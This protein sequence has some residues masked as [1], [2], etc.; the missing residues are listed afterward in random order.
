MASDSKDTKF[1]SAYDKGGNSKFQSPYSQYAKP[2]LGNALTGERAR[3]T[4]A[5]PFIGVTM[6]GMTV[7]YTGNNESMAK[8]EANQ[9]AVA[10]HRARNRGLSG[11]T[12][13][14]LDTKTGNIKISA[15]SAVINSEAGQRIFNSD[16]MKGLSQAYKL[17]KDYKISYQELDENGNQVSTEVTIPEYVEK[18][19]S[20]LESLAN[21]ARSADKIRMSYV[22]E[23]GENA[24]KLT[25]EQIQM[26]VD[27]GGKALYLPEFAAKSQ[28]L[29]G[30]DAFTTNG[31][32]SKDDFKKFYTRDKLG[33]EEMAAL[34][35][36]IN[37]RLK[38]G[39][40]NEDEYYTDADGNKILDRNSVNEMAKALSLRNYILSNDPDSTWLQSVGDNIESLSL[41][42][43][44]GFSKVFGNIAN[45]GEAVFTLG[46]SQ[47]V[48]NYLK[49]W[50]AAIE[51]YNRD[52]LLV[53]DATAVTSVL[54]Q[55]GGTIAGTIAS[56]WLG[57][58]AISGAGKVAGAAAEKVGERVAESALGKNAVESALG[59]LAR[60]NGAYDALEL[61]KNSKDISL[62]ARMVLNFADPLEKARIAASTAKAFLDTHR[63]ANF[64]VDFLLDTVHDA[65]LYDSTTLR[66][67]LQN[68]DQETRDYW[69]GQ[70]AE[71]AKWWGGMAAGKTL[72]KW[73]GKTA[74]GQAANALMTK[75][76]NRL[77]AAVG[78]TKA[79]IKD[80]L[81]GGSVLDELN[82]KYQK[83][84]DNKQFKK[85]NR[86]SK[87]IEQET[88]NARL[89]TAR[90]NLGKLDLE[91]DG[92]KLTEKSAEKYREAVTNIKMLENAVDIYGRNIEYKRQ[93]MIGRVVD[94]STGKANFI[95]PELGGANE[96]ASK[97]Y[98][99]IAD[100]LSKN[101]LSAV[102]DSLISQDAIDYMMGQYELG[103]ARSFSEAGGE[104]AEKAAK[105]IP[106]LEEN[107]AG[108]KATLPDE[109]IRAIDSGLESKTYQSFYA[110]LNEY[111][112]SESKGLLNRDKIRSYE[113]NQIWAENGY[114]PIR[115]EHEF[116]GHWEP[117]S[118]KLE[119]IIDDDMKKLTFNVKPGQHYV[120]PELVRQSR[121]SHMAHEEVSK[122]VF[123]SYL[124]YGNDAMDVTFISGEQTE[125]V[126]KV[127][128]NKKTLE[129]TISNTASSFVDESAPIELQKTRRRKPTKNATVGKVYREEAI[130]DLSISDTSQ[131]LLD[132][133][134][135]NAKNQKLTDGVTAEN[136]DEWFGHQSK[137]VKSYLDQ[138]YSRFGRA[139][140]RDYDALQSAIAA[141]GQDFEAGLQR[142][143]LMGDP[144]FARS[145]TMNRAMRNIQDGKTAF[146][147]GVIKT[148]AKANL[149]NVLNVKVDPLVDD[150]DNIITTNLDNYVTR[151]MDNP[152]AKEAISTLAESSNGSDAVGRYIALSQLSKPRNTE[153]AYASMDKMLD[154]VI[155]KQ[156]IIV[157]DANL[158]KKQAHEMFDSIL[159]NELDGAANVARTFN[160]DLIDAD[161]IY[162]K[163][164]SLNDEIMGAEKAISADDGSGVV[165]YLDS[166]GRQ[167]FAR[168]DPAFASLYNYRF[169]MTKTEA[170]AFAKANAAMSRLFRFGTTTVNLT[171]F[172]NQMFRDFGNAI[173]VGGAWQT[174]KTNADNLTDVFGQS[175]V[176]QIKAF[177]PSGYDM[178]QVKALAEQT[179]QTVEQA[180]VSRELMRGAAIS[181]TTT[182]RTLYKEFM[183]QA[184]GRNS[185]EMLGDMKNKLQQIVDK[186]NP[187]DLLNG[188]RENYLRN[189]VYA[190]SLNDAM[191]QGYTLEQARTF[192]EFAMN[193]ATTNFSRQLYH[194]Q[195]IADSTPYFRAAINGTKSFWRMWS[196]DPVGI[197]G[198]IVGGLIL[199]T[200]YLTGASLANEEDA[201]I[202]NNIPEYQK[203]NSLVFVHDG[204]IVTIPIPQELSEVVAPFRQ[205]VEYLHGK[206]TSGFWELMSNDILG[207]SPVDLT[208][209]TTVDMDAIIRD[210]TILD[211]VSRGTSRVFSQMAPVPIKTA[212]ML[213]THTDPYTGK[214]LTDPSYGYYNE[215]TGTPEVMDYTQNAFAKWFGNL[216]GDAM[217]PALAEKIV[218]GVIGNTGL[219]VLGDLSALLQEGPEGWIDSVGSNVSTRIAKP[220]YQES[221]SIADSA[222]R[223]A[224]NQ[225]EAKKESITASRDYK[226]LC[227]KLSQEKDP[228][229][230]KGIA[231]QLQNIVNDY[232]QEVATAIK[233]LGTEYK[234]TFDR[235]KFAAVLNLLN[236]NTDPVFQNAIQNTSI[237]ASE[238]YFSG[239]DIA[240]QT[241]Q[242]L[243]VTGTNDTSIFGY[244]TI[245]KNTGK[246]VVKYSNPVAIMEME[247]AWQDQGD[248]HLNNIKAIVNR[249]NL[250]DAK[251]AV[252]K[253]VD[254]IY[255]KEKLSDSDY[256]K[257]NSIYINWNAQV[258][259]ALAPYVQQM[260][261]EAAI[262]SSSVLDYLDGLIEVPSEF[263]KDR[264]GRYVTN[265]KLGEGSAKQA[266]VRNYIKKI[267]GVNDTG[268]GGGKDYSGRK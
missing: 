187:D 5:N 80:S 153:A 251:D 88:W 188:K 31:S 124:G 186:Y 4:M 67:A 15:P 51:G 139:G 102:Q 224:V 90:R 164:K 106:V 219:D 108:Y 244:L 173:L 50:D 151:I 245:D 98:M 234:G 93:E 84:Y 216:F 249:A 74:L 54:G 254:A 204:G 215:E 243:G 163:A 122:Q 223:R 3:N 40:W 175:I 197:S 231:A 161:D 1:K 157:D 193:N 19:N 205:F 252:D 172:G 109:T 14:S 68:S 66:E 201:K 268:Y 81:A 110:Q 240:I 230:R 143:F 144:E 162:S 97:M 190:S 137:E 114:M 37:A 211:R 262:N 134:T 199:P 91:W 58:K 123:G 212:Y 26:S 221:Y 233:R 264:Y 160:P 171:S 46:Q 20:A 255:A 73:A 227:D 195:A 25:D 242:R 65:L 86:I 183:E 6:D 267:F 178:R 35:G 85:A 185:D 131:L 176:D 44:S 2:D 207:F 69:L 253:Q 52:E 133:G 140:E 95:N 126:R 181:P 177:E 266:Y 147:D 206:D 16:T 94:P 182:E 150:I 99:D 226:T 260:T 235:K 107:I 220:F 129:N 184:Y 12:S 36:M 47:A 100:S 145:S 42:A 38:Y 48:Q 236:F 87:Q 248:I 55:I 22:Q 57:G 118:G 43:L 152:G 154:D 213:A 259:S 39:G 257:I 158:I 191:K 89:R 179:G 174:I 103:L 63:T 23:F 10:E 119:N 29:K 33:R 77:A 210:P 112:T 121:I 202:Y 72:V 189:R 21:S 146:Y 132:K 45:V 127:N 28:L 203:A 18:L 155:K 128:D 263:K 167:S 250:W 194:M 246:P 222:W 41:N 30:A 170:S 79:D 209:F 214:S 149:Q 105:A 113:A 192:A 56:S 8:S 53:N 232:Q 200:V 120:D 7:R 225:L 62:G 64:A 116:N 247:N 165:M 71:N 96:K 142:A 258:M 156:N 169:K 261:P 238:S 117:E 111:G 24:E 61:V 9:Q 217:S 208:A 198:R 82:K 101:G 196:L 11:E 159:G 228:E 92:I 49:D 141:R 237:P 76:V 104:M 136:Y 17:N 83:A 32:I 135:I 241:M 125:Y 180:A 115:V 218:S 229:K 13:V 130:S 75:H 70:L 168:I 256:N 265:R 138:Q 27:Y 78:D 148:R 59:T 34:L 166:R 60:G 239:N